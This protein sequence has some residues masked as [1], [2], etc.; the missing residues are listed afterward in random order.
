MR[1]ARYSPALNGLVAVGGGFIL[2]KMMMLV[3]HHITVMTN[4]YMMNNGKGDMYYRDDTDNP[5]IARQFCPETPS[6]LGKCVTRK[7]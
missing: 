5:I 4:T 1:T 2:I 6:N 3:N 7:R